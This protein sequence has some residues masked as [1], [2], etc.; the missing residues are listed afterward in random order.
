M[1]V[2]STRDLVAAS[3][4]SEMM[5]GVVKISSAELMM[6]EMETAFLISGPVSRISECI[7]FWGASVAMMV[8]CAESR[9]SF[10]ERTGLFC[11]GL[12]GRIYSA[13]SINHS[14]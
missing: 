2:V 10:G 7:G 11:E 5:A 1:S 8:F 6:V 13:D 14:C 12:G 3:R 4:I 9:S